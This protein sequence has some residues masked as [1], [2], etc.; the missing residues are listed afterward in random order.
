MHFPGVHVLPDLGLRR[1]C[2]CLT[3]SWPTKWVNHAFLYRGG[4]NMQKI[5]IYPGK[6][7]VFLPRDPVQKM[8]AS[9]IL[10]WIHVPVQFFAFLTLKSGPKMH[11]KNA[12]C[13]TFLGQYRV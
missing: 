5:C 3:S 9:I 4:W 6:M 7:H 1:K 11:V 8:H 13:K 12:R 10:G 2:M